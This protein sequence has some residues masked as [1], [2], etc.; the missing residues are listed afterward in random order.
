MA[1]IPAT[2]IKP[3][4]YNLVQKLGEGGSGEVFL[5]LQESTINT[6]RDQFSTG[7]EV[8]AINWALSKVVAVKLTGDPPGSITTERPILESICS[9]AHLHAGSCNIVD[10]LD[11][12]KVAHPRWLVLSTMPICCDRLKFVESISPAIPTNLLWLIFERTHSVLFF[13]ENTCNP[14]IDHDDVQPQNVLIGFHDPATEDL[15][16]IMLIDFDVFEL[17][18]LFGD[19]GAHFDRRKFDRAKDNAMN[20]LM[21]ARSDPHLRN[22]EL[23]Q[24]WKRWGPTAEQS[25]NS[26]SAIDKKA[27][28][29]LVLDVITTNASRDENSGNLRTLIQKVLVDQPSEPA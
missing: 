7:D 25:L 22:Q 20:E 3:E 11:A 26:M 8:G 10:L 4:S 15:P 2:M 12:E 6:A 16:Q 23:D 29:D 19:L 1:S 24:I 13:L 28:C 21:S 18:F 14:T 27:I 5:A 9:Q 17:C